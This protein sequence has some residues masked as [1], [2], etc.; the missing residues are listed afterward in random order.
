MIVGGLRQQPFVQRP[1]DTPQ[2]KTSRVNPSV[3]I[4]DCKKPFWVISLLIVQCPPRSKIRRL[5][6]IHYLWGAGA[7]ANEDT[8]RA[9]VDWRWKSTLTELPDDALVPSKPCGSL[10][11]TELDVLPSYL[12]MPSDILRSS[13]KS[14]SLRSHH[15]N[16]PY[17]RLCTYSNCTTS[18]DAIFTRGA[19]N[20]NAFTQYNA[21]SRKSSS[22][23]KG[24]FSEHHSYKTSLEGRVREFRR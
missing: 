7:A 11:L 15:A 8:V 3:T 5:L 4:A 9:L 13:S 17:I 20:D 10:L 18:N 16:W 22:R 21:R 6:V 1:P 24:A 2:A 23:G 19:V 14:M 12:Q